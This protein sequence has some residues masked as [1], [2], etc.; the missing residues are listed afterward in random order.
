MPFSLAKVLANLN[1]KK[2]SRPTKNH[3]AVSKPSARRCRNKRVKFEELCHHIVPCIFPPDQSHFQEI[4]QLIFPGLGNTFRVRSTEKAT[5][6]GRKTAVS[7][8]II[9][10]LLIQPLELGVAPIY[11]PGR[12]SAAKN[13]DCVIIRREIC[14]ASKMIW[15]KF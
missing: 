7:V 8:R 15:R 2:I 1:A 13:L 3:S 6:S 10:K 11:N 14:F 5:T 4:L 12:M 9:S